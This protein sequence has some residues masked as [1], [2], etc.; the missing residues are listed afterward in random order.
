MRTERL[1]GRL[2]RAR[3][4]LLGIVTSIAA[5]T[6]APPPMLTD[7][8]RAAIDSGRAV[9]EAA[10]NA[11]D[12]EAWAAVFAEDAEVLG[13]NQPLI[14]GR[15]AIAESMRGY[16]PLSGVRFS[17]TVVE[18]NAPWAWVQ[19]TYEMTMSPPGA[20]VVT[21]RGKYMEV[22][23]QDADGGWRVHRLA[24]SSDLPGPVPP[25]EAKP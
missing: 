10:A 1:S 17:H 16:P 22:W 6:S 21:D 18:G 20:A 13:P 8:D 9:A 3:C 4:V 24:F 11:G 25:S 14:V 23:R 12:A 2:R 5:C 15:S 7:A 19:G